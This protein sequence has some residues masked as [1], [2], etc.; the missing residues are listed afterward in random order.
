VQNFG[1]LCTSLLTIMRA[2]FVNYVQ[3]IHAICL[4]IYYIANTYTVK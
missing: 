4:V 2:G 1:K 3:I